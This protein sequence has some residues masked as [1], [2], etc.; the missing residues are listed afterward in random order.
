MKYAGRRFCELASSDNALARTM[1]GDFSVIDDTPGFQGIKDRKDGRK[2]M[3][4]ISET[5]SGTD[6]N[7]RQQ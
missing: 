7:P 1:R 6:S 5:I 3:A 2:V 4:L